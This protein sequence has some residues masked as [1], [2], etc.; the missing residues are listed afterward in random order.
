MVRK[1]ADQEKDEEKKKDL[2]TEKW[3]KTSNIYFAVEYEKRECE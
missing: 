1:V 3:G 2:K